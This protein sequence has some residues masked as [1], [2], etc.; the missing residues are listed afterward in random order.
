MSKKTKREKVRHQSLETARTARKK[1]P[2]KRTWKAMDRTS[3]IAAGLIAHRITA[4]TWRAA[5][6]KKPPT[7]TRHP[8]V[9]NT[10]AVTWAVLA[11]ASI[12]LTKV[13]IHRGTA[14]YWVKS[15]GHLPPGMKPLNTVG[16]KK[17]GKEKPA[18]PPVEGSAGK[19]TKKARK[20]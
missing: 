12:E 4:L 16:D 11:G 10:E 2:G 8:D 18:G 9:S 6:G 5:T 20:A 19:R 1:Q 17:S 15:T 14:N 7:S 3:T 13:L